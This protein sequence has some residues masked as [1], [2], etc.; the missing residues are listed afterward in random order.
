M[1]SIPTCALL[2]KGVTMTLH[3]FATGSRRRSSALTF[4]DQ[5]VGDERDRNHRKREQRG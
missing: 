3:F 5:G 1:Q 2:E 4:G